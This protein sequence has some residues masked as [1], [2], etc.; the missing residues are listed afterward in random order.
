MF[1]GSG[2]GV[3]HRWLSATTRFRYRP[4]VFEQ[5]LHHASPSSSGVS[6]GEVKLRSSP[7]DAAQTAV[8]PHALAELPATEPRN[9]ASVPSLECTAPPSENSN[10]ASVEGPAELFAP[11]SC[12]AVAPLIAPASHSEDLVQ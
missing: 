8:W 3:R 1:L 11:L 7:L 2:I 5:A 4:I 10:P 12:G 6:D 9:P